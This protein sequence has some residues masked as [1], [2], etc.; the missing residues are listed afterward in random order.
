MDVDSAWLLGSLVFIDN[1][2]SHSSTDVFR[3]SMVD[4]CLAVATPDEV[5]LLALTGGSLQNTH[6]SIPTDGVPIRSIAGTPSGRIF[7][8]GDRIYEMEYSLDRVETLQ[9]QLDEFYDGNRLVPS[10]VSEPNWMQR[11][12]RL[13]S[14]GQPP[15]KSRK[16]NRSPGAFWTHVFPEML[17]PS[18]QPIVQLAVDAERH[19][20]FALAAGGT[21]QMMGL[22]QD[23][24]HSLN[25][26]KATRQYLEAT[27]RRQLT[28]TPDGVGGMDG[29]RQLL[30]QA[31]TQP[32]LFQPTSLHVVPCRESS[33]V[34]LV[35]VTKYGL[36]L[37]VS[38]VD[39]R[40]KRVTK[41]SLVHVRAPES[42]AVVD[43]SAYQLGCF[44]AAEERKALVATYP[45]NKRG[46]DPFQPKEN[47]LLS[48]ARGLPEC[49]SRMELAG[50]LVW[51]VA[52]KPDESDVL[53]LT[54]RSPP[55]LDESLIPPVYAPPLEQESKQGRDNSRA[56]VAQDLSVTTSPMQILR[57]VFVN[58]FLTRPILQGITTLPSVRSGGKHDYRLSTRFATKG[59]SATAVDSSANRKISTGKKAA[60]LRASLLQPPVV[61]LSDFA[62]QH[63]KTGQEVVA[64]TAQG[65]HV[66]RFDTILTELANTLLSAPE[67]S[68]TDPSVLAFFK[69]YGYK[70]GCAM[71]LALA[72]GC[73]P[74][75]DSS[76]FG[77]SLRRR[78]TVAALD[79]AFVPRL[80]LRSSSF[81]AATSHTDSMIPTGYEFRASALCDGLFALT[82]RLLR[83]IWH[84]PLVV[85]TEGRTVSQTMSVRQELTPAKV[86][87][88]LSPTV[89]GTTRAPLDNLLRLMQTTFARAVESV[90]GVPQR[91]EGSAMDMDDQAAPLLTQ[92]LRHHHQLNNS[93]N[94]STDLPPSEADRLAQMIEERNIHS[95]YRLLS[96]VVQLLDALALLRSAHEL[97]ELREVDWGQLHGLTASQLVQSTEGQDRLET[98]L[99][100]LLTGSA[101][102]ENPRF[103]VPTAQADRLAEEFANKCFLFFSA[104][105]RLAYRGLRSAHEAVTMTSSVQKHSLVQ[106]AAHYFKQ[107]ASHWHSAPLVTGR[108][109]R[110]KDKLSHEA[111]AMTAIEH[112]SPIAMAVRALIRL[113]DV[114]S[115]VEVAMIT[116]NNFQTLH[117]YATSTDGLESSMPG[118][119][120]TQYAWERHLYH[121]RTD[122]R[123]ISG[124]T[125][126]STPRSVS[127]G[128]GVDS[129]DAIQTCHALMFHAVDYLLSSNPELGDRMISSCA[130][131]TNRRFLEAFYAFLL[132]SNHVDKLLQIDSDHLVAWIQGRNDTDLVYRYFMAQQDHFVAA[133]VAYEHAMSSAMLSFESRRQYLMRAQTAL[134]SAH[135]GSRGDLEAMLLSVQDSIVAARL[136]ERIIR[137]LES[138][139]SLPSD[140]T[141]ER[142]EVIKTRLV[143]V[144]DLFNLYATSLGLDDCCLSIMHACQSH[145]A[146]AI[147]LF[148]KNIFVELLLPC[149]TRSDS[150]YR[151][152][153]SLFAD[154]DG[155]AAVRLLNQDLHEVATEPVFETGGWVDRVEHRVV[156][157]GRD[158]Y[159]SGADYVFPVDFLLTVLTHLRSLGSSFVKPEWPLTTLEKAGVPV[160]VL[161]DLFDQAAA[162]ELTNELRLST[163][164]G[165]LSYSIRAQPDLFRDEYTFLQLRRRLDRLRSEA[166]SLPDSWRQ[167]D[168]LDQLEQSIAECR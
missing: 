78:A 154:D 113:E 131:S 151:G 125:G 40:T 110:S 26:P 94:G 59:F 109:L 140:L 99:N 29:A 104:G 77:A 5:L 136:Q 12:R 126:S 58:Y 145:D 141:P 42:A 127:G 83:P 9:S 56:L 95:M 164:I 75:A 71:C 97:V 85:V 134:Q 92:A 54:L 128:L 49:T 119:Q 34:S 66:F 43:A 17:L 120:V 135:P 41:L 117:Q 115:A 81:N 132:E 21:L 111:I 60:R 122:S 69:D 80:Q 98:L 124:S 61:P 55:T 167:N 31:Q 144:M 76:A 84:K 101:A 36:R 108:A 142:V 150:I 50:G 45:E 30:K 6:F 121:K 38:S 158:L 13:L 16:L 148:W 166:D 149:A 68:S 155:D 162:L 62:L 107:A 1:L 100:T 2:A 67:G 4:W 87:L 63:L 22:A 19:T 74:A 139:E 57:N 129:N 64:L 146:D 33:N 79:N 70:E 46:D 15:L 39:L 123:A 163:L 73:G 48:D 90:P 137:A 88:L 91:L 89:L 152:L 23:L 118:G 105:S 138:R 32:D 72:V 165:F 147:A 10:T 3:R 24:H 35:V 168:S 161:I 86:E 102:M 37:Y 114:A 14:G 106:Q 96:R 53:S 133:E 157:L 116:I 160:A 103:A 44:V 112:G 159:G 130:S 20:L 28:A 143:S 156:N 65:V 93:Q 51:E 8:G 27:M 82:S 18:G 153:Q 25:L 47:K 7:L 52:I 11:S